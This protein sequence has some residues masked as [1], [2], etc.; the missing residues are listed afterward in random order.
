VGHLIDYKNDSCV[1]SGEPFSGKFTSFI[2]AVDG[3]FFSTPLL[4]L[5]GR[6]YGRKTGLILWM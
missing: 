4:R 5:I 3:N 1:G 6:K 2:V